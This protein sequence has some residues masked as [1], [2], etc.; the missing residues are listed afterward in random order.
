MSQFLLYQ[1]YTPSKVTIISLFGKKKKPYN[2][3]VM[4]F[5]SLITTIYGTARCNILDCKCMRLM[6]P[7]N[8]QI[9]EYKWWLSK[10][11]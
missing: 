1:T 6:L 2:G 9:A 5:I 7:Y 3:F 10:I 11:L 4:R 8:N